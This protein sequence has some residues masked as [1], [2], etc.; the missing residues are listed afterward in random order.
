[1]ARRPQRSYSATEWQPEGAALPR[2]PSTKACSRE[3]RPILS[4]VAGID[5][6]G[7]SRRPWPLRGAAGF[8]ARRRPLGGTANC[9]GRRGDSPGQGHCANGHDLSRHLRR[10]ARLS[11]RPTHRAC[12]ALSMP[13]PRI[14][15]GRSKT[16]TSARWA[17]PLRCTARKSLPDDLVN[18]ALEITRLSQSGIQ[19][20]VAEDPRSSAR[21]SPTA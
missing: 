19:D 17:G 15:S 14:T 13:R 6:S 9:Q 1:M 20:S 21:R 3:M 5:S 16:A 12:L 18:Q 4:A 10:A 7:G 11:G 2:D 8:R